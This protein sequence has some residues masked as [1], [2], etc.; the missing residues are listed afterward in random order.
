MISIIIPT[1]NERMDADFSHPPEIILEMIRTLKNFDMVI[2]PRHIEGSEIKNWSIKRKVI[3]AIAALLARPL[4]NVKDPMS[5]FFLLKRDFIKDKQNPSGYKIGLEILV[6]GKCRVKEL[7]YVFRDRKLGKKLG[8]VEYY[9][10]R[11][12]LLNLYPCKLKVSSKKV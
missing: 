5:G 12:H 7:P 2:A 1:Y 11:L 6:S 10:Y 8:L 9:N 3:S 4:T